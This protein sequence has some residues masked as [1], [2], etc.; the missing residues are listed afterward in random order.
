MQAGHS[1]EIAI[2][3]YA[4]DVLT[5]FSRKFHQASAHFKTSTW[6]HRALSFTVDDFAPPLTT[7]TLMAVAR[8]TE[9]EGANYTKLL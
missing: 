2:A 5:M 9:R 4:I 1:P 8:Q 3:V 7:A 6:W